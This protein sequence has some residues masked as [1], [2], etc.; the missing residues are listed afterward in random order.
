MENNFANIKKLSMEYFC[1]Y[2]SKLYKN[3][4]DSLYHYVKEAVGFRPEKCHLFAD[5]K[6]YEEKEEIDMFS[7]YQLCYF[8]L[9]FLS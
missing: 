5:I 1:T 6:A 3:L 7:I 8:Q 4:K 9:I 2:T